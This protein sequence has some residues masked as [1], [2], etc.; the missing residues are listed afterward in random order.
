MN[1]FE[2][3]TVIIGAIGAVV[4]LISIIRLIMKIGAFQ[5]DNTN[6]H[7]QTAEDIKEIK[8]ILGNGA[9]GIRKDIRDLDK[10]L[11]THCADAKVRFSAQQ[12][13]ID[14]IKETIKC[15]G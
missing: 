2:L 12:H 15:T 6:F 13:E 4:G 8:V 5:Q 10:S 1:T 3:I 11:A 9:G 7:K 14:E